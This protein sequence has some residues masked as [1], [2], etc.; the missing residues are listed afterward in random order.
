MSDCASLTNVKL[1]L[2]RPTGSGRL[3]L[4][5]L[6]R[7]LTKLSSGS[8]SAYDLFG[9]KSPLIREAPLPQ[10]PARRQ[11]GAKPDG[12]LRLAAWRQP[13]DKTLVS[14][15]RFGDAYRISTR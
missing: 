14:Q 1:S 13:P 3:L 5:V 10:S 11:A 15:V 2:R 4:S 8:W 12:T 6:P 9:P 7:A